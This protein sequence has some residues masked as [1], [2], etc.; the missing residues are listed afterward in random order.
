MATSVK[1]ASPSFYRRRSRDTLSFIRKLVAMPGSEALVAQALVLDTLALQCVSRSRR[2]A[3]SESVKDYVLASCNNQ[4]TF[5]KSLEAHFI[6]RSCGLSKMESICLSRAEEDAKS[7]NQSKY[8]LP[9][10]FWLRILKYLRC[11]RDGFVIYCPV[12]STRPRM[13]NFPSCYVLLGGG[14][15][16]YSGLSKEDRHRVDLYQS[17]KC[18]QFYLHDWNDICCAAQMGNDKAREI[19]AQCAKELNEREEFPV[20]FAALVEAPPISALALP[21]SSAPGAFVAPVA[22]LPVAAIAHVALPTTASSTSNTAKPTAPNIPAPSAP[23]QRVDA[24]APAFTPRRSERNSAGVKVAHAKSGNGT[25]EPK[26]TK[27]AKKGDKGK[28]PAQQPAPP[29]QV[30]AVAKGSSDPGNSPLVEKSSELIDLEDQLYYA[31]NTLKLFKRM[32]ET[33]DKCVI[34]QGNVLVDVKRLVVVE[35]C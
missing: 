20:A 35:C 2:S 19:L 13:G 6:V 33:N 11:F 32:K 26:K 8:R 27:K 22:N 1:S 29:Q 9:Q 24:Q 25:P 10:S 14:R 5:A 31:N 17:T 34:A 18:Y 12:D 21:C 7:T 16:F 28:A 23:V 4:S 15:E 3:T 30:A